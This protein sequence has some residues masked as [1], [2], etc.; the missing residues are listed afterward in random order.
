MSR[1]RKILGWVL[2]AFLVYAVIE[3]P[4]QAADI[5]RTAFDIIAQGVRAIGQFFDSLLRR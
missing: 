2:L 5:V 1:V 3:S 4:T